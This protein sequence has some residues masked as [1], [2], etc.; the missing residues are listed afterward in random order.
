MI[1]HTQFAHKPNCEAWSAN[2]C[3]Q[4]LNSY[5]NYYLPALERA[6]EG[7][8]KN[9]SIQFFTS[10]WLGNYF[11]KLMLPEKTGRVSKKIKSP[12]NHSPRQIEESHLVIAEFLEQQEKLIRLLRKAAEI[13]LNKSKVGISIAPFIKLKVGDVLMFLVAHIQRHSMQAERALMN[14]GINHPG[15]PALNYERLK[16]N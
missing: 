16:E 15:I 7:S 1:P 12:K 5:G 13:D 3:L 11:T 6:I 2:E 9:S 10:G 14:T 8:V 4:H